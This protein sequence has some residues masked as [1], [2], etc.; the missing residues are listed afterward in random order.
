MLY[1]NFTTKEI[2]RNKKKN[3]TTWMKQE[4][5]VLLIINVNELIFP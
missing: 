4:I 3:I 1:V 2:Q 5:R